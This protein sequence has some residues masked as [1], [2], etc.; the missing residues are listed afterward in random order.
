MTVRSSLLVLLTVVAVGPNEMVA[1]GPAVTK[2]SDGAVTITVDDPRP[3]SKLVDAVAKL[4]KCAVTYEDAP[5]LNKSQLVD[6]TSPQYRSAR[7][8]LAPRGGPLTITYPKSTPLDRSDGLNL[9]RAAIDAYQSAGYPA[10][11]TSRDDGEF[12]HVVPRLVLGEQG[13][14][15]VVG[16]LLD[17]P[18]SLPGGDRTIVDAIRDISAAVTKVTGRPILAGL[19]PWNLIATSTVDAGADN[20][21]A[22]LVLQRILKPWSGRLSWQL[23]YDPGSR[24][25]MLSIMV[26]Q[27][28][29]R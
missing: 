17:V 29:A 20:E 26:V 14:Q 13:E 27:L 12:I 19:R 2:V 1:Q 6:V 24:N 10:Q 11:F 25:Y 15:K 21:P 3:L 4:C 28:T 18:I 7:R 5:L 23:L 16:S 9:I 8:A 22:R